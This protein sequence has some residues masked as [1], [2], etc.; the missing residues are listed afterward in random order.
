MFAFQ[1]AKVAN[2][3]IN[4]PVEDGLPTLFLTGGAA[5]P[6]SCSRMSYTA[7]NHVGAF[8]RGAA[9]ER[10]LLS[11]KGHWRTAVGRA[12]FQG[13]QGITSSTVLLPCRA[14]PAMREQGWFVRCRHQL[15]GALPSTMCTPGLFGLPL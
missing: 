11:A 5:V 4:L 2:A 3:G 10:L 12:V 15:L 9:C 1:I 6:Y 14:D 8:F 13:Q 7:F